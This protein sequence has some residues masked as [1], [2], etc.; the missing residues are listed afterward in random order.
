MAAVFAPSY[1]CT[2]RRASTAAVDRRD[3][4]SFQQ[5]KAVLGGSYNAIPPGRWCRIVCQHRCERE[6][7][8]RGLH[9]VVDGQQQPLGFFSRRTTPAESHYSA[10]DLEL[11]AVYSTIVKF[12]HMLEGRK[13]RIFMD[14]KPLTSAFLKAK[15]P[16]SNRQW[17]Q[18]AFISEFATDVAHIPRL[19]NVV[20]DALSWQYD[21]MGEPAIVNAIVHKFVDV[22]LSELAQAQPRVEEE[23][24]SSLKLEQVHFSGVDRPVV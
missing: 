9:Q 21:D 14:Q 23:A 5:G 8:C 16:V 2:R 10:Y 13:F 15:D 19:E 11:L 17:H 1:G 22:D 12:R 20:A 4:I 6:S 18:L 7:G 3:D 24:S